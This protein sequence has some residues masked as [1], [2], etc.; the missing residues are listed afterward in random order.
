[1][2]R[3]AAA[4][5]L[6]SQ[7]EFHRRLQKNQLAP[8][9]LLEGPERYLRDQALKKLIDSAVD[10]TVRDFNFAIQKRNEAIAPAGMVACGDNR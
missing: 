1:M 9:Y 5:A 4:D 3:P 6:K 2:K 7:S 10:P 8:L